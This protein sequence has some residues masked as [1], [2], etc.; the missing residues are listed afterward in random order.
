MK[1]LF[2]TTGGSPRRAD[3]PLLVQ[4]G[5]TEALSAFVAGFGANIFISG[6]AVTISGDNHTITAGWAF[7]NNEIIRIPAHTWVS[8]NTG[9]LGGL[10]T[11][12]AYVETIEV[13]NPLPYADGVIKPLT[14][15]TVLK[16][17]NVASEPSPVYY[18]TFKRLG[19]AV[20]EILQP[21]FTESVVA[22]SGSGFA[23][24]SGVSSTGGTALTIKKRIDKTLVINGYLS[25]IATSSSTINGVANSKLLLTVDAAYRPASNVYFNAQIA[26]GGALSDEP[27]F[28][29][30]ILFDDGKL[31]YR[32]SSTAFNP[33]LTFLTQPILIN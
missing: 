32:Q 22:T 9:L 20:G 2:L 8:P 7:Y 16:F 15:E 10:P 1:K 6:A 21:V 33:E 31:V 25:G 11:S 23:F 5:L 14:K 19:A 27:I 28:A 29:Q 12:I 17:K 30:F 18:L 24:A 13:N 3:Y 26:L 4:D